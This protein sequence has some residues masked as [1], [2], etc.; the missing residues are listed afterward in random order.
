MRHD[1]GDAVCEVCRGPS[2]WVFAQTPAATAGRRLDFNLC[3]N[4]RCGLLFSST[5]ITD[6]ELASVYSGLG[7]AEYYERVGTV[8]ALKAE[9][10]V[11]ELRGL[12]RQPAPVIIDFGCGGGHFLRAVADQEP[13]WTI[14]GYDFDAGSVESCRA[15][16]LQA[17]TEID[18]LPEADVVVMLDVAE[19][20]KDPAALFARARRLLRPGGLLYVHTPRRC[21]WDSTA[22]RLVRLPVLR[23]VA[24]TWLRSRV[25]IYHLRL[26]TDEALVSAVRTADFH[27][28]RHARQLELSWPIATYAEVYVGE[29]LGAP[30]AVVRAATAVGKAAVRCRLLRNKAVL[31]AELT[32]T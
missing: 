2:A 10:A 21:I 16:G 25:S 6:D 3:R 26:W 12:V 19:H 9:A 1:H 20:V 27:V 11:G 5:D 8:S 18:E 22:L 32:K 14:V 28:V 29:R 30:P 24:S 13:D 15:T 17:T 4:R 31:T 7:I 23:A